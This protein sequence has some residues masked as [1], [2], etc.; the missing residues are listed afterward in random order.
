MLDLYFLL[1]LITMA[2]ACFVV[3]HKHINEGLLT[4]IGILFTVFGNFGTAMQ[5]WSNVDSHAAIFASGLVIRVGL[6]FILI[7]VG[8]KDYEKHICSKRE[9]DAKKD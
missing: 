1:S 9:Q 4:K 8:L 2:V 3:F 6:L 7:G 5:L